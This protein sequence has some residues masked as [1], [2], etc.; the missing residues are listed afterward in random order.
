MDLHAFLQITFRSKTRKE[1]R[2]ELGEINHN[3]DHNQ[4]KTEELTGRPTD[5]HGPLM[6]SLLLPLC[7]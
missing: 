7:A 3:F 2:K 1:W 4:Q 5:Y 6:T